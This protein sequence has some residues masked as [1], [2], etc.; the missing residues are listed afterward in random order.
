MIKIKSRDNLYFNGM[1]PV[2]DHFHQRKI[3]LLK[4]SWAGVFREHV[5]PQLPVKEIAKN[6]DKTMGRPTKELTALCGACVLQQFF[7]LTDKETRDQLAFNQQWHYALDVLDEEDQIISLKTL[8]TCRQLLLNDKL[9]K[10]IFDSVTDKLADAYGIDPKLQRLD[11]VHIHSNMARLGRIRI[12]S[13]TC[14]IFLKNL[15]RHHQDLYHTVAETI[16]SRYTKN[17]E[18]PDYF[19]NARP[20]DSQTRLEDMAPDLYELIEQFKDNAKVQSMT[21]YKL[22]NRVFQEHCCVDHDHVIVKPAKEVSADSL[23]N[24]SD[25]D[26]SY[27]GH[28]GQGYQVQIM[29]T[30]SNDKPADDSPRPSL[31]LITYV[32]VEPAHCHDSNAVAPALEDVEPRKLLPEELTADTLYGSQ[33]NINKAK[34]HQVNLVAPVPGKKPD[35]NLASFSFDETTSEIKSCPQDHEP[36]TIKHNNKGSISCVWD[37]ELCQ[38]CRFLAECRVIKSKKG[39]LLRYTP[40]EVAATMR[41]Q[42]EQSDEFRDKYRYRSGIEASISRFIH[43]T[44][45]RRL[46]YRGLKRV[47]YA[48]RLK[49]LGINIFRTA[50]FLAN[51][52]N[53][54]CFA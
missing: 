15:K 38:Q 8:W 42:Y 43:Q 53:Q 51:Q 33:E 4:T 7:D 24:P 27:D 10:Q 48:A 22:L 36:K 54:A 40:K 47:D 13:R 26:A 2:D 37:K 44:G 20:S 6:F 52:E 50:Q 21:S 35:H 45:A 29:E 39:Y 23:Q 11:S 9:A 41:R 16:K 30:Y 19:G 32:A 28:K 14:T 31:Q 3:D 1:D 17:E 25:V 5:L 34:E 12:L 18:D 46:R 49:A